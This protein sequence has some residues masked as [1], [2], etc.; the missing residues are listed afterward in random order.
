MDS[1]L[2]YRKVGGVLIFLRFLIRRLR[3][4]KICLLNYKK[5]KIGHECAFGPG[6]VLNVPEYFDI[7]YNNAFARNFFCQTN[8]TMGNECLIS[9]DVS[10]VGNDHDLFDINKTAFHSGRLP[11]STVIL[12]GNNFIGYRVVIVGNVRIGFGAMVAAGAVVVKDVPPG[13]IVGGVPA[14][15]IGVRYK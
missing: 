7:G 13:A 1:L 2:P 15:I 9:S 12:E 3:R 6:A 14:R 8:V 4:I 10:F 11:P 5:I